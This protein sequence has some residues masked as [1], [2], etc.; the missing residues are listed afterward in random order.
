MKYALYI[1]ATS[2]MH[3]INFKPFTLINRNKCSPPKLV[4]FGLTDIPQYPGGNWHWKHKHWSF[5][6]SRGNRPYMEDRMHYLNDPYHNLVM[7]SIFDGHGGPFVS[8]YLE[9]HFSGAIRQRLLRGSSKCHPSLTGHSNDHVIEAIITEVHNI[10]DEIVRLHPSLSSLTGSTLISVILELNRFLTVI[11]IGDSRAVACDITGRAIPL[12][13][14]HKP[15]DE[16][17]RKRIE[18]AGG[19]IE[20]RGVDRL[21]GILSVSRAFGDTALKQLSVLTA[22]P[23]IVRIDLN[24]INLQFILVASDG[25]WD[26][27]T[28]EEAIHSAQTF[29]RVSSN[30][31][32]KVAEYLVRK[33]LK[34]GS[35]DN[36]SL[37]FIRLF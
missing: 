28:N 33:A 16:N 37:L 15:S 30:Q 12:S 5:Y 22:Q 2:G 24:E 9:E 7:F 4:K 36:V 18:N 13:A 1:S 29:L 21:Q 25:F 11:N 14:D 17:E 8:Q 19:F 10:D 27:L 20:F 6:A 32:Q 26:V 23:D 31:W 35:D 3:H 34:L